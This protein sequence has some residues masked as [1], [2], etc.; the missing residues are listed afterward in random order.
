MNLNRFIPLFVD[1]EQIGYA[2]CTFIIGIRCFSTDDHPGILDRI[3]VKYIRNRAMN[4]GMNT[5]ALSRVIIS[6]EFFAVDKGYHQN[7]REI[8]HYVSG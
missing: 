2:E 8:F 6:G 5:D 1:T 3:P 4:S 7:K